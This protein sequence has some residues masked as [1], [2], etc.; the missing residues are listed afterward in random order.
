MTQLT[1]R[2]RYSDPSDLPGV[3]GLRRYAE[4][5]L[6]DAGID[7]WTSSITGD[8]V[9][10][11]HFEHSNSYVVEDEAG[12]LVAALSLGEGDSDFWTPAELAAPALYLYKFITGPTAR[13]TGLGDVLLDWACCQAELTWAT[14][15]RLDCHRTNTGLHRYYLERGFYHVDTR[16]AEGRASGALFERVAETRLARPARVAL[17]DATESS[18]RVFAE[19]PRAAAV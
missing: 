4:Q 17:V 15:L 18:G 19:P 5:W 9:I 1:Y 8:R 7:Q 12:R 11:E 6:A 14:H 2:I 10:T 16:A 3:I 13:G